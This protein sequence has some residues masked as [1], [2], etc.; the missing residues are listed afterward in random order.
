MNFNPRESK[1]IC[2]VVNCVSERFLICC[3]RN[4][5]VSLDFFEGC[6]IHPHWNDPLKAYS[7]RS[8]CTDGQVPLR[9]VVYCSR[10]V[11]CISLGRLKEKIVVDDNEGGR[12][13][14]DLFDPY[15]WLIALTLRRVQFTDRILHLIRET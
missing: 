9:S 13:L 3:L 2:S 4:S 7:V 15:G 11:Y 1:L 14:N 5:I 10:I 8:I 6:P 12:K